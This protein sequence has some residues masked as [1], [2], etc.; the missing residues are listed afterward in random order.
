MKD[1]IIKSCIECFEKNGFI[2][3]SIQDVVDQIGVT[4]GTFYYYFKSKE[5]VLMTI[6]RKYIDT[7]LQQQ[8]QVMDD[9]TLTYKEKLEGLVRVLITN[10]TPL[11]NSARVF[12]REYRHLNEEHMSEVRTKR[13]QVR[14][15]MEKVIRDGIKAKEFRRDIQAD[16]V[17]LGILGACN[18]SYQWFQSD[19]V[20]TDSE[21]ASIFIDMICQGIEDSV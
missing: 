3:T 15:A 19:G 2:E 17:T 16:I 7:L 6:H 13:N 12:H 5:Q 18:W 11:G 10:I 21:V 20:F 9:T 14:T 1:Q 4:K 8:Q